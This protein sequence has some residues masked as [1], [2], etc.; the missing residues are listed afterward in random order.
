VIADD[1]VPTL[2]LIT[3]WPLDSSTAGGSLRYVVWAEAEAGDSI[4]TS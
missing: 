1:N 3:C 2:I 4:S